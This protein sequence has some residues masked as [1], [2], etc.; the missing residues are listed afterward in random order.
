MHQIV[1][2]GDVQHS[3]EPDTAPPL[4]SKF[5]PE[6]EDI[7]FDDAVSNVEMEQTKSGSERPPMMPMEG[8]TSMKRG[9]DSAPSTPRSCRQRQESPSAVSSTLGS[10][11]KIDDVMST[12]DKSKAPS[13]A[14]AGPSTSQPRSIAKLKAL[15]TSQPPTIDLESRRASPRSVAE[16]SEH[17]EPKRQHVEERPVL[18]IV[19]EPQDYGSYARRPPPSTMPV[20]QDD[21]T[22]SNGTVEDM[23]ARE[24]KYRSSLNSSAHSLRKSKRL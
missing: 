9:S 21:H 6:F 3:F 7:I 17:S 2:H 23:K 15:S 20:L 22:I 16:D 18:P 19:G 1:P 10:F 13:P 14:R 8:R 11:V 5:A 12:V 4:H 24:K